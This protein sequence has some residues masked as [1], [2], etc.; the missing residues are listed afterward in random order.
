MI[1]YK[2]TGDGVSISERERSYIEKRFSTFEKFFDAGVDHELKIIATS[3]TAHS[4]PDS[5]KMEAR[6]KIHERD[7][8]AA[9][10]STDINSAADLLKEE[11]MREV[12]QSNNRR[13][14]LFHRGARKIKDLLKRSH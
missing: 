1:T 9:S 13:R 7:F 6:M 11:L 12:T 3:V 4:R 14:T 10:E 5:I 2:I 8:F